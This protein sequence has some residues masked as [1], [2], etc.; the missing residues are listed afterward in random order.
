MMVL[1]H[2]SI[3]APGY[4]CVLHIH[5][6]V[7]DVTITVCGVYNTV[8][9]MCLQH[10]ICNVVKG[11]R[12]PGRPRFIKEGQHAI[13]RMESTELFCLDTYKDFEQMGRVMLRDEGQP[14]CHPMRTQC[15]LCR[16]NDRHWQSAQSGGVIRVDCTMNGPC[17]R[18]M[19]VC[20]SA[21]DRPHMPLGSLEL[22][23]LYATAAV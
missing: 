5:S 23:S 11:E 22:L 21:C 1:E 10:L 17:L 12:V 20:Y 4:T 3:I 7:E 9:N 6:A 2:K 19:N 16:Q 15:A 13:V 18:C 8:C 14:S